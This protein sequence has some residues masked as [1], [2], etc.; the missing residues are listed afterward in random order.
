M[1][2][3]YLPTF[4]DLINFNDHPVVHNDLYT[5]TLTLMPDFHQ[6]DDLFGACLTESTRKHSF[7]PN[8][9]ETQTESDTMWVKNMS[10][11]QSLEQFVM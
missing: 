5:D 11:I 8:T 7:V 10:F 4:I 1:H 6:L 9:S 3:F 2:R